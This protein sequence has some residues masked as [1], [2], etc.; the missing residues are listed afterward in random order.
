MLKGNVA[1]FHHSIKEFFEGPSPFEVSEWASRFFKTRDLRH[2]HLA[3]GCLTYLNF[4]D[5]LAPHTVER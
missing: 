4:T 1:F 3:K 2:V 5:F